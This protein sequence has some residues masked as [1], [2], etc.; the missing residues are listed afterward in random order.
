MADVTAHAD[1]TFGGTATGNVSFVTWETTARGQI[2]AKLEVVVGLLDRSDLLA[3]LEGDDKLTAEGSKDLLVSITHVVGTP[4]KSVV[5]GPLRWLGHKVDLFLNAAATSSG[6][7]VG[8][9]LGGASRQ[10]RSAM[11]EGRATEAHNRVGS[12]A[13]A[14]LKAPRFSGVSFQRCSDLDRTLRWV[15][16][17]DARVFDTISLCGR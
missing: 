5:G 12:G 17:F 11:W 14:V 16:T 10:I 2:Q 7:A 13:L 9:A 15:A 8:P 6:K 1:V 4:D 3:L